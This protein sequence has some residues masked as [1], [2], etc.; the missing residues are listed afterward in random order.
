MSNFEQKIKKYSRQHCSCTKHLASGM[1]IAGKNEAFSVTVT[2]KFL[3]LQPIMQ[4]ITKNVHDL[5]QNSSKYESKTSESMEKLEKMISAMDSL[6]QQTNILQLND[7]P[8]F[9]SSRY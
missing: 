6:H 4:N 7:F 5:T 1:I 9:K 3:Q 8:G 2:D